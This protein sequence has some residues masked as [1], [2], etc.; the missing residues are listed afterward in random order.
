MP[1]KMGEFFDSCLEIYDEHQ[2]NCIESASDFLCFTAGS[3]P[4]KKGCRVLDLGCGTGLKLEEYFK[5]NPNA[6]IT[7]IDLAPGTLGRLQD[8]LRD[9]NIR[10]IL[11]SY[12]E[13]PF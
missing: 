7:G 6:E 9:K 12:F 13:V 10:V 8:K 11:G 3:L 4:T 2:L 5:L 1:E